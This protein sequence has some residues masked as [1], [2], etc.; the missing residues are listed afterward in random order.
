MHLAQIGL[1]LLEMDPH[2]QTDAL[3]DGRLDLGIVLDPPPDAERWL[4]VETVYADPLMLALPRGHPVASRRRLSLAD[5]ADESFVLP[6][7]AIAPT[8]Y[9]DIIARCRTAH[10]SPRVVQEAAAWHTVVSL[11]SAGVGVAFVPRSLRALRQPG[12]LYRPV[13][14]LRI[15][16]ELLAIWKRGERSPVRDRFLTALKSVARAKSRLSSTRV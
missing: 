9:D 6:P 16:M 11:V 7:R 5:L 12:V 4:Q 15:T 8:L 2:Q 1:S 3:R 10:F 13:R 14:D